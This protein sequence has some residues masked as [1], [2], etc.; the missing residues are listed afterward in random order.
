[1]EKEPEG[2][3]SHEKTTLKRK[4]ILALA[5]VVVFFVG[6]AMGAS[7]KTK[8]VTTTAAAKSVTTTAAAKSVTDKVVGTFARNGFG[9]GQLAPKIRTRDTYCGWSG[10]HVIVH[11]TMRNTSA[12]RV[13]VQWYPGYS[14]VNGNSHGTGLTSVQYTSLNPGQTESVLIGQSPKGV[15]AGTRIARC[16]PSFFNVSS[17]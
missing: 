3:Q 7:G 16:Y 14:I 15:T 17:D 8:T 9:I 13:T 6:I 10:K 12:E 4:L 2:K 5:F 1:M 11:V